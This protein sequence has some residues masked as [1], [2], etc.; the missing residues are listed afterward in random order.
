MSIS[1]FKS[2][3]G[4][5]ILRMPVLRVAFPIQVSPYDST[6]SYPFPPPSSP[7]LPPPS[8]P[9]LRPLPHGWS[10]A[11]G[12]V[13]SWWSVSAVF[14]SSLPYYFHYLLVAGHV[15]GYLPP[16][17]P[18][19]LRFPGLVSPSPA[20]NTQVGGGS[21]LFSLLYFSAPDDGC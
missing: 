6:P 17:S 19:H 9:S 14:C 2:E 12:N 10:A 3:G 1:T 15:R 8:V 13:V 20:P 7:L 21:K 11:A 5:M 4:K 18:S 16:P